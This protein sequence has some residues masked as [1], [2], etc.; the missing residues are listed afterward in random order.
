MLTNVGQTDCMSKR[1]AHSVGVARD[2]LEV[3]ARSALR[4]VNL[5]I[6][7]HPGLTPARRRWRMPSTMGFARDR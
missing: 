7:P 2:D 4:F 3:G 6:A 5:V 1:P